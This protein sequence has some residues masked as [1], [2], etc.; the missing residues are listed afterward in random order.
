MTD[1]AGGLAPLG[2]G[3]GAKQPNWESGLRSGLDALCAAK[4]NIRVQVLH[5]AAGGSPACQPE[6]GA[7]ALEVAQ[8]PVWTCSCIERFV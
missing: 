5:L 3:L 1:G 4:S 6:S 7:A 8:I 2:M